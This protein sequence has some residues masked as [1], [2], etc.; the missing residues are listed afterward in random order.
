VPLFSCCDPVPAF[1]KLTVAAETVATPSPR[2]HRHR[3]LRSRRK[4]WSRSKWH[5]SRRPPTRFLRARR[6]KPDQ[7]RPVRLLARWR[8]TI[9]HHATRQTRRPHLTHPRGAVCSFRC[10]VFVFS[11]IASRRQGAVFVFHPTHTR[12]QEEERNGRIYRNAGRRWSKYFY[13]THRKKLS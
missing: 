1:S 9:P 5:S 7:E 2:S 6:H 3:R 8:S 10:A 4:R 11:H 13:S 12:L